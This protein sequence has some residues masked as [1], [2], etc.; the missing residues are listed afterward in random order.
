MTMNKGESTRLDRIEEKI[1]K[2]ADAVVSIARA[3]EKLAGLESLNI[4][5]HQQ[6]QDLD[7]RMRKVETNLHDVEGAVGVLN[8][9]F[10]IALTA[11][12]TGSVAMIFWGTPSL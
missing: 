8:K 7:D 1:D 2:L 5:Q 4:A 12:I 11:L 6:L 3:E 9:I 10:W